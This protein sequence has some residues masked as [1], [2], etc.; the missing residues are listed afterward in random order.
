MVDIVPEH[1]KACATNGLTIEGPVEQFTQVVPCV[2]PDQ[3][4]GTYGRVVLAVKAQATEPALAQ[5]KPHLANAK[6]HDGN[7]FLFCRRRT[8]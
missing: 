4:T 8:G 2:T 5:L 7:L 3:L 6:Q 1:A